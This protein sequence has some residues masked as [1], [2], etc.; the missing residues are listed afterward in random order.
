MANVRVRKPKRR[1]RQRGP[2]GPLAGYVPGAPTHDPLQGATGLASGQ[3]LSAV[4]VGALMAAN[5]WPRSVEVIAH[6]IAVTKGESGW[7]PRA[8]NPSSGAEGLWQILPS[9]HPDISHACRIDPVCSTK[10]MAGLYSARG[11]QPWTFHP[12]ASEVDA[13]R[14]AAAQGIELA[15]SQGAQAGGGGGISL[16]GLPGLP[17]PLDGLDA[18]A[19]VLESVARFFEGL[20]ELLLT[21]EGWLQIAKLLGGAILIMAGTNRLA[22]QTL[23]V[24]PMG[25]VTRAATGAIGGPVGAV[26]GLARA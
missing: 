4:Q 22:Q 9:A 10:E 21:P 23:G 26:M 11:W 12:D 15:K 20:G 8:L 24:N 6:G 5:G 13:Q 3:P 1:K 16:P 18:I 19:K 2:H 7:N 25:A 14:G 17:N